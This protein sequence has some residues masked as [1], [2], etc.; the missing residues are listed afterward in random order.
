MRHT[1]RKYLSNRGSALFMVLSTMTALMVC[2]MAMYFS[3]ISSRSTQYAIFNQQQAFQS[4][5]SISDAL[6]ASMNTKSGGL[7]GI[8]DKMTT[9]EINDHITT[10]SNNFA[11]FNSD[12]TGNDEESQLGAYTLEI[13]RLNDIEEEGSKK[14]FFDIVLTTSV[15]GT[16]QVLHTYV[17]MGGGNT[18]LPGPSNIFTA[19]GYVP[20]DV[21]VDGGTLLTSLFFD[22]EHTNFGGFASKELA[23]DGDLSTGGTLSLYNDGMRLADNQTHQHTW[24]IR[25]DLD[26]NQYSAIKFKATEGST[27]V[28][29]NKTRSTVMVGGDLTYTRNA[30]FQNA[31]VYVYGDLIIDGNGTFST[32]LN[33]KYFVNGNVYLDSGWHSAAGI[34]HNGE[35]I[36]RGSGCGFNGTFP[37]ESWTEYATEES[38]IMNVDEMVDLLKEKTDTTVYYKWIVD[39]PSYMPERAIEF[40]Y[41]GVTAP[42]STVYLS[43]ADEK[44]CV[45]TD[46]TY[47]NGT[48]L[49]DYSSATLVI[50]TG[51]NPENVYTIK[52][53]AN[54]DFVKS[55][56]DPNALDSFCFQPRN[57]ATGSTDANSALPFQVITMGRGSVVIEVPDGVIYQ[58]MDN[59]K[60]MHYGW[61]A[62]RGGQEIYHGDAA[63]EAS[64][65]D[66]NERKRYHV[67]HTT[68]KNNLDPGTDATFFAGFVHRYCEAG[69]GCEYEHKDSTKTCPLCSGKLEQCICKTHGLVDTYCPNCQASRALAV[70]KCV[71]RI[72][73]KEIDTYLAS[74]SDIKERMKDSKGKVIYPN[75]NNFLVS[76]DENAQFMFSKMV[77]EKP[78]ETAR[79][80]MGNTYFGYIYAPYMTFKA[81]PTDN[82]GGLKM[83]GGLTVSDYV[84]DGSYKLIACWPD[85][86]P[87]DIMSEESFDHILGDIGSKSWKI[88][89]D[90]H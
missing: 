21:F 22:N 34:Y 70:G 83:V 79:I 71:N 39:Y 46:V 63:Y 59:Q 85:K 1:L 69:D 26:F 84:I 6:L 74:H 72:G 60:F 81:G 77:P 16:K 15:N 80:L 50:D 19:T 73:I 58:D 42:T 75:V 38:G 49:N 23:L 87:E 36:V 18:P 55:G 29:K 66:P 41:N 27:E 28:Q 13:T 35:V 56:S 89:F 37:S 40:K 5:S 86:M 3:V 11:A 67:E 53:K 54:R 48:I 2:C 25:G 44:G 7:Q 30:N 47:D 45:I 31:N 51:E 52:L 10:S 82:G 61:F 9:M 33:N 12:G 57:T 65:A 68:Y 20:N 90:G 88:Q 76:C 78:D 64:I 14:K 43:Y 32:G 17:K 4:A 8:G 62:L 24:A